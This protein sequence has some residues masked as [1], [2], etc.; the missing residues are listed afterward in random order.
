MSARNSHL[1]ASSRSCRCCVDSSRSSVPDSTSSSS[2][3]PAPATTRTAGT[4]RRCRP[5]R[6]RRAIRRRLSVRITS[7][8][9]TLTPMPP[10][11]GGDPAPPAGRPCAFSR[12]SHCVDR[13][14]L[15]RRQRARVL[16][17]LAHASLHQQVGRRRHRHLL[18][19]A[20]HHLRRDRIR[21]VG[22]Q[23]NRRPAAARSRSSR[24][25]PPIPFG[26]TTATG[27]S[28]SR[29]SASAAARS[30]AAPA[31]ARRRPSERA[32]PSLC[33]APRR[34]AR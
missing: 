2:V 29:T 14:L 19:Q 27:T 33:A 26:I 5:R 3:P 16:L 17:E 1:P 28:P 6:T 34:D 22:E 12:G 25:P 30:S 9:S 20:E 15:L 31:P 7:T 32:G 8:T 13:R 18:Q 4:S 11:A 10:A 21:D 24:T 23:L